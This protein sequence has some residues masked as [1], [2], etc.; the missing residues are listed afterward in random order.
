MSNAEVLID[1]AAEDPAL[2]GQ[3]LAEIE[4]QEVED[5]SIDVLVPELKRLMAEHPR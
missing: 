4:R 1:G 3:F 2:R 5:R